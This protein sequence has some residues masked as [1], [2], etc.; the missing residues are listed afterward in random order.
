ML[1]KSKIKYLNSLKMGKYRTL[2]KRFFAEGNINVRDFIRNGLKP[3]ELFAT[4]RWIERNK[5]EQSVI[6]VEEVSLDD[7]KKITAL[8]NPSEV[9][10]LFDMPQLPGLEMKDD[11]LILVL[12]NIKD[13]GNLGTIIRSAD[14]F[15]L[16]NIVCSLRTVEVYNPKVVQASMGSL[17]RV[18]VYYL[19]LAS[20]FSKLNPSTNIYGAVLDGENPD[21]LRG[22]KNGVLIIGS[23]AKGIS[24]EIMEYVKKPISIRKSPASGAE[25][26]NASIATAILLYAFST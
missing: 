8:K 23:E 2:H 12:D 3:V 6:K 17:A 16:K 10:A 15:G 25:S 26:L 21:G 7:L 11:D 13:P 4:Q 18:N 5:Q 9:Y 24:R 19:D 22:E 1:S 14:W 20:W